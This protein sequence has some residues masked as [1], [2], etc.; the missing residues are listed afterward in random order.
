MQTT[1]DLILERDGEIMRL[2]SPGVGAFTCAVPRGGLLGGGQAAG[3]LIICG[4]PIH[5]CVPPGVAGRVKGGRPEKIHAPVGYGSL[6]YELVGIES[7]DDANLEM[8]AR[9]ASDGLYL[10]APQT[11]RF[12]QRP[13]PD[14]EAFLKAGDEVREGTSLGLIEVMKT[15]ALVSY[16][17]GEGLPAQTRFKAFIAGDGAEVSFG[18]P[19]IEFEDQ[20]TP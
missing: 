6:L 5:L 3:V 13:G 4:R 9:A 20:K 12:Y 10:L 11:G 1:I 16:H 14:E 8:E 7:G 18:E 19:L 17:P 15:F 2:L